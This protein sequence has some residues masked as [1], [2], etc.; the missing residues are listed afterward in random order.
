MFMNKIFAHQHFFKGNM[1]TILGVMLCL[2]F[3]YHAVFGH[4]SVLALKSLN[5]QIEME[6]SLK[7]NVILERQNLEHKVLAMRPDSMNPD[8]VE[9]RAR[10]VL[11]Y[12]R[13]DE[14]HVLSN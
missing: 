13:V 1:L 6:V 2:Y 5:T 12:K 8:M 4:R 14:V 10:A 9:E 11:G 3:S 7:N